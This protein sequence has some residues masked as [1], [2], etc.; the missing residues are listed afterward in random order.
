MRKNKFDISQVK[1]LYQFLKHN[2]VHKKT[3]TVLIG[4][5]FIF[6]LLFPQ[7]LFLFKHT[8]RYQTVL[9]ITQK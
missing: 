2:L 3:I 7:F 6:V 9:E 1:L 4:Q 8:R 5:S